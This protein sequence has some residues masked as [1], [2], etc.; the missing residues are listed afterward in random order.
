MKGFVIHIN[1][2]TAFTFPYIRRADLLTTT[3]TNQTAKSINS[4][5]ST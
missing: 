2:E 3:G 1:I 5:L 4:Q